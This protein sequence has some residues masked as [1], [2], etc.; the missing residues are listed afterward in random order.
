MIQAKQSHLVF[1]LPFRTIGRGQ[2]GHG[3]KTDQDLFEYKLKPD[4]W[5]LKWG[6][7]HEVEDENGLLNPA[8][9][10]ALRKTLKIWENKELLS[11]GIKDLLLHRRQNWTL[12]LEGEELKILPGWVRIILTTQDV[13]M[14]AIQWRLDSSSMDHWARAQRTLTTSD[15]SSKLP[16]KQA[17]VSVEEGERRENGFLYWSRK[18][19]EDGKMAHYKTTINRLL[20]AIATH[21]CNSS[22]S[23]FERDVQMLSS[24][25]LGFHA[26]QLDC[27]D[28]AHWNDIDLKLEHLGYHLMRDASPAWG[29]HINGQYECD[30][31][32]SRHSFW[33]RHDAVVLCSTGQHPWV[34]ND[35]PVKWFEKCNERFLSFILTQSFLFRANELEDQLKETVANNDMNNWLFRE[36]KRF[37]RKEW[38][39][40]QLNWT[41]NH[42]LLHLEPARR[43]FHEELRG[44]LK[45]NEIQKSIESQSTLIRAWYTQSFQ[46]ST[47]KF[48]QFGAFI[49]LVTG[50]LGINVSGLT[51]DKTGLPADWWWTLTSTM[52]GIFALLLLFTMFSN[53]LGS[54]LDLSGRRNRLPPKRNPESF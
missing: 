39:Y 22:T 50:F 51:S 46:N 19:D 26:I 12:A 10:R 40:L 6:N 31:P 13:A 42:S 8:T 41:L 17:L 11:D 2:N 43:N 24:R 1:L 16:S 34:V 29:R 49:G 28:S 33:A 23:E 4:E 37:E 36:E 21:V 27:E 3:E 47:K 14:V 54:K 30:E 52:V 38:E 44:I 18:M 45:V 15:R 7:Q 25:N 20:K 9:E 5:Q 53:P 32:N 35:L 48:V